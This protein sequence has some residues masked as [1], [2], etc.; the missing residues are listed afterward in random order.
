MIPVQKRPN[1]GLKIRESKALGIF[2][3]G[4]SKH[5]VTSFEQI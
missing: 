2:V 3:D 4:L 1:N 5:A